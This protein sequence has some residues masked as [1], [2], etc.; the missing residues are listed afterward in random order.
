MRWWWTSISLLSLLG[1]RAELALPDGAQIACQTNDDCPAQMTCRPA[2]GRCIAA[3]ADRQPP[4]L[5]GTPSI[6]PPVA[7]ARVRVTVTLTTSEPLAGVPALEAGDTGATATFMLI[8]RSSAE[9]RYSFAYTPTGKE[10]EGPVELRLAASDE[11]GNTATLAFTGLTFDFTA[12]ASDALVW[13]VP[14]GR[15]VA[16]GADIITF[17]MGTEADASLVAARVL[18]LD[19]SKQLDVTS[20][21]L[22][23]GVVSGS[24]STASL[25]G[26]EG[27][28]VEVVLRDTAGNETPEGALRSAP[29]IIDRAAPT[30]GT[31][32]FDV[33]TTST[34]VNDLVLRADGAT[35]V[36]LSG[37]VLE[38]GTWI[39]T[40][41]PGRLPVYVTAA[42]GT[43]TVTAEFAD[44]AGNVSA[45]AAPAVISY[46][47][48]QDLVPPALLGATAV[49]ATTVRVLFTEAMGAAGLTTP[50]SYEVQPPLAVSQVVY[51]STAHTATLTTAAQVPGRSYMLVAKSLADSFGNPLAAD[52]DTATFTGFGTASPPEPR[53]PTDGEVIVDDG[54]G[55]VH[56]AWSAWAAASSYYVQL[57]DDPALQQP[58]AAYASGVTTTTPSATLTLTPGRSYYWRVR[59]EAVATFG[60]T[61]SFAL[62]GHEVFVRCSA[63]QTC[64]YGAGMGTRNAPYLTVGQGLAF[65][66]QHG[67]AF[68]VLVAGRGGG[69]VYGE[70]LV[71]PA[72]V[73]LVGGYDPTFG[74]H[75]AA[76]FPTVVQSDLATTMVINGITASTPTVV[77]DLTVAASNV[78][79]SY[80]VVVTNSDNGLTLRRVTLRGSD[81]AS[82]PDSSFALYMVDSGASSATGPLF[83]R[84]M[85]LGAKSGGSSTAAHLVSSSPTF[86][87]SSFVLGELG[88]SDTRSYGLYL[89]QSGP[90]VDGCTFTMGRAFIS[91]AV[92]HAGGAIPVVRHTRFLPGTQ[93]GHDVAAIDARG[94]LVMSDSLI[95]EDNA[96][97]VMG[98]MITSAD[99][100]PVVL[101]NVTFVLGPATGWSYGVYSGAG[102]RVQLTN[103]LIVCK[104][105]AQPMAALVDHSASGGKSDDDTVQSFG[106]VQNN[107]FAG[108]P[109]LLRNGTTDWTTVAE[110]N[111]ATVVIDG[112]GAPAA[113]A[114][115]NLTFADIPSLGLAGFTAGDFAL[116]AATPATVRTG[117]KD[118]LGSTCGRTLDQPCQGSTTD[119]AGV[120]RPGANGSFSMGAFE[121]E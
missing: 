114:S 18:G 54:S 76:L 88:A 64:S 74:A 118:A 95:H 40:A 110:I 38:A 2:L 96:F 85:I 31:I 115:G 32:T 77:E 87:D 101:T 14:D 121:H 65:A 36:R 84:C 24:F 7:R 89:D 50:A 75:D 63:G 57:Y 28:Q 30:G 92:Y 106:A 44:D 15:A 52:G 90:L 120:A 51:D 67:G 104:P 56:L 1:C 47:P 111:D 35:R 33:A 60:P 4:S 53:A 49:E 105:S 23:S 34:Q 66:S 25:P 109:I 97:Y 112:P 22:T 103:S 80:A 16:S 26:I 42:P 11:L 69:A 55:T 78:G 79:A 61:M 46:N 39:A 43:K 21:T 73:R 48:G 45:A 6:E 102:G 62:V 117:G 108:C 20:A 13:S 12:P 37:D 3:N 82:N 91:Y 86:L 113:S 72:G 59:N 41:V 99:P 116:T 100:S 94:G 8:T 58:T 10:A 98:V 107:A 27:V 81:T 93:L 70:S 17:T 9:K 71:L 29:L 19:G 119:L 83:D 5:V 68:D